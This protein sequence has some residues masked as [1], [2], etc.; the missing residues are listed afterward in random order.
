MGSSATEATVGM[1][2]CSGRPNLAAGFMWSQNLGEPGAS[3]FDR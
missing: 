3:F 2:Q 1:K